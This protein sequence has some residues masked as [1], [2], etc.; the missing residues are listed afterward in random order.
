M[1]NSDFNLAT[2]VRKDQE[3]WERKLIRVQRMGGFERAQ[4]GPIPVRERVGPAPL[5]R[6]TSALA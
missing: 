5:L 2:V 6:L 4:E 3:L 1:W